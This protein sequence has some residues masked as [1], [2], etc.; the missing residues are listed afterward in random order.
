MRTTVAL[1][2]AH[3]ETIGADYRRVLQLAN[4]ADVLGDRD[5][6]LILGTA[7]A[8]YRPGWSAAPWQLDGTLAWL[9]ARA[10]GARVL[11]VGGRGAGPVP[12]LP[13]WQD[14]LTRYRSQSVGQEFLRR[15]LHTSALL[16]PA[17]DTVLPAGVSV[18][19][20]LAAGPAL[21]LAAPAVR[22]VWGVGATG[23]L[24]HSLIVAGAG[25]RRV[26]ARQRAP[27]AEIVAEAVGVARELMPDLGAVVD[28]TLWGVQEKPGDRGRVTR[29]V[30][31][32]GADPLAVDA[33]AMRLAGIDPLQVPWIR[34]CHD[35]GFGRILPAEIRVVGR[36][37]F[38]NL[39][40]DLRGGTFAAGRSGGWSALSSP[41]IRWL[42]RSRSQSVTARL[43]GTAW[44]RLGTAYATGYEPSISAELA[45]I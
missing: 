18:P 3:P 27:L 17:L 6:V 26:S 37:D 39:D 24:L 1:V 43:A 23:V 34:I 15:H 41:M 22:P 10:A 11:A 33:V 20:G 21:L 12:S 29:N 9:G 2:E 14:C 25:G 8:G 4:L 28:G 30:I 7:A 5:P 32:A 38:L 13:L 19:V 42:G 35:R 44:E 40:F 16:H 36:T 45:R 31:L